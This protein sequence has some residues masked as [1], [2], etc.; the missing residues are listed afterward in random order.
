[1]LIFS[2]E[3]PVRCIFIIL[4]LP[5]FLHLLQAL[6]LY[7][8]TKSYL[9]IPHCH[10]FE[11]KHNIKQNPK[12]QQKTP[13]KKKIKPTGVKIRIMEMS[14]SGIHEG[15]YRWKVKLWLRRSNIRYEN[16]KARDGYT[17]LIYLYYSDISLGI[18]MPRF[19]MLGGNIIS[20]EYLE[21]NLTSTCIYMYTV[22][23][24][25]KSHACH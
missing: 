17:A 8:G 5:P 24:S 9:M 1:M 18:L 12:N 10:S 15:F 25:A 22:Y 11:N 6:L 21:R 16:F 13:K 20:N 23:K 4:Y 7:L 14:P 3:E 2:W 19:I